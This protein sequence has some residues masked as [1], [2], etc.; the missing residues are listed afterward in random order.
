MATRQWGDMLHNQEGMDVIDT[1]LSGLFLFGSFVTYLGWTFSGDLFG[2]MVNFSDVWFTL[3]GLDF[4]IAWVT[5]SV[6]LT[7]A[8]LTNEIGGY[9][10]ERMRYVPLGMVM[11]HVITLFPAGA[12]LLT[13]SDIVGM[14]VFLIFIG[15][16][17]L[18]AWY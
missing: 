5:G 13:S 6:A 3:G 15:G 2:V 9:A 16:Y 14:P 12:D 4:T 10:D 1:A 8:A 11:L 18:I 7:I 17:G